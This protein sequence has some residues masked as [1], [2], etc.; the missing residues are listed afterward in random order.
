MSEEPAMAA[1]G[2]QRWRREGRTIWVGI[3]TKIK[4]QD[5]FA[6]LDDGRIIKKIYRACWKHVERLR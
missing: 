1:S 5:G 3:A 6:D 4:L 2:R